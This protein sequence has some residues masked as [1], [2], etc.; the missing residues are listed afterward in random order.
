INCSTI[1]EYAV[2]CIRSYPCDIPLK[3]ATKGMNKNKNAAK[4]NVRSNCTSAIHEAIYGAKQMVTPNNTPLMRRNT[5]KIGKYKCLYVND[6]LL[7]RCFAV[8][9]D[10]ADGKPYKD[11]IITIPISGY[12]C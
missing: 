2:G 6:V 10:T 8:N 3:R 5:T 1:C 12:I 7:A 9:V 4:K 11:K